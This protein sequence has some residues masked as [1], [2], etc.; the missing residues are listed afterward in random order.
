[1][2]DD[3]R[4]RQLGQAIRQFRERKGL[5]RKD[6]VVAL[7]RDPDDTRSLQRYENGERL[8]PRETLIAILAA[9][10]KETDTEEI[11]DLVKLAYDPPSADEL[12]RHELL[13]MPI[14][15][16]Q[17]TRW[18]PPDRKEAGISIIDDPDGLFI[19][20]I[21]LKIEIEQKLLCQLGRHIPDGCKV[22]VDA[23]HGRQNWLVRVVTPDTNKNIGYV[24]FGGDP[25]K[26]WAFDG[27]VRVGDAPNDYEAEV[28]QVFQRYS[29]GSYRRIEA[30][31][32]KS[33]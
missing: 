9:E 2:R 25:E 29:D 12:R 15:V 24:W 22:K 7:G 11:N 19:Y 32:P 1:M 4:R 17:K 18:G 31:L 3:F 20:W 10:G 33:A 26:N 27:L 13:P 16:P 8:P 28:W 23:F 21:D 5:S 30:K 14:A 6:V